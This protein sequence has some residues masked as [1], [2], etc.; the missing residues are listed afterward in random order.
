MDKKKEKWVRKSPIPEEVIEFGL[1]VRELMEGKGMKIT[2]LAYKS[3]LETENL[4]KYLNGRQEPKIT[5][6]IR[7]AE[8]LGV[9]T[10]ELFKKPELK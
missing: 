7:I 4:R 2:E 6:A 10:G 3:N 8:A 9:E 5:I 1:R